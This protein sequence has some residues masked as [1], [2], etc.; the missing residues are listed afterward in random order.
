MTDISAQ[1]L[2][3]IWEETL[4]VSPVGQD[5]DFFELGG[6]SLAA[7]ELS[8]LIEEKF[9]CPCPIED[10]FENPTISELANALRTP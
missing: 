1:S 7:T 6:D 5:D 8:L 3:P 2:I 10:I 9:G 4:Q